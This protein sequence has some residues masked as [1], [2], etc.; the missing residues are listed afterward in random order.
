MNPKKNP[1]L[2][3]T[4]TSFTKSTPGKLFFV[5]GLSGGREVFLGKAID[6]PYE[7]SLSLEGKLLALS[8]Q[9]IIVARPFTTTAT[10]SL[11]DPVYTL[12]HISDPARAREAIHVLKLLRHAGQQG[13]LPADLSLDRDDAGA[14]ISGRSPRSSSRTW[15]RSLPPRFPRSARRSSTSRPEQ[16]VLRLLPGLPEH[17]RTVPPLALPLAPDQ[18]DA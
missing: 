17:G 5:S 9:G 3:P 11:K 8:P 6:E 14:V 18:L 7:Q 13:R 10:F 4:G 2:M 15:R 1:T 12:Q 16:P